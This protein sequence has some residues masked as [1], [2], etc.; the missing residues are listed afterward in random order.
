MSLPIEDTVSLI[1]QMALLV[2]ESEG[3]FA[4]QRER[5]P[6][7]EVMR[8]SLGL[9][10]H[11]RKRVK[12]SA[13]SVIVS[14]VGLT[15]V[16][17]STLLNALLGGDVAPRRNGPCT[18]VPIEFKFGPRI[19]I[20]P[21]YPRRLQRQKFD[22]RSITELHEILAKLASEDGSDGGQPAKVIV[23]IPAKVL[24]TG[25]IIADTPGFGA[26]IASS[27]SSDHDTR[28]LDYLR[29]EATQVFWVVMADQGIGKVE[30]RVYNDVL[31]EVCD[32]IIV[33]G[34]EDW[35]SNDRARFRKRFGGLLAGGGGTRAKVP[36]FHFVSGLKGLEARQNNDRDALEHAG[37]VA[38][39]KRIRTL[40]QTAGRTDSV[41]RRIVQLATELRE[42]L[43][44]YR[45][46]ND[47]KLSPWFRPD[48]FLRFQSAPLKTPSHKTIIHL[49]DENAV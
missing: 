16:G 30:N 6:V 32:D 20:T 23:E 12:S 27:E 9:L 15:N 49:L 37:I 24:Q 1:D 43:R 42:W 5:E 36:L 22:A 8:E 3:Y 39:G 25:L 47:F 29:Y 40:A 34:A 35:D 21:I 38:L 33:T 44:E 2:K 31:A 13:E 17:K 41:E 45:D 7:V 28:L 14:F 4:K 10:M 18:S 11:F 46:I 48:S 26:A 19:T